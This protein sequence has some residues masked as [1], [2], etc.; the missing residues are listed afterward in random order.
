MH[1]NI[2]EGLNNT[3]GITYQRKLNYLS[4]CICCKRHQINKPS[5]FKMWQDT[6]DHNDGKTIYSC[7]CNCR[8]LAR[9]I[10]READT[11]DNILYITPTPQ[12]SPVSVI[13][14]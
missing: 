11:G 8:H 6:P 5:F 9:F 13:E 1:Y 3:P 10:C 4:R 2:K 14:N 12:I 7:E